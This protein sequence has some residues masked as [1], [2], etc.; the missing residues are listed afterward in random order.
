MASESFWRL[1]KCF[2]VGENRR[3]YS[4]FVRSE[5]VNLGSVQGKLDEAIKAYDKAI[6]LDKKLAPAWV[7]QRPCSR[8]AGQV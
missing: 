3:K 6:E 7:R 4:Y 2:K 1:L 8:L 5:V